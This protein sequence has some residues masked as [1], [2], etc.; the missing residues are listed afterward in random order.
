MLYEPSKKRSCENHSARYQHL[1]LSG[2][3][4]SESTV[5]FHNSLLDGRP[6]RVPGFQVSSTAV[7]EAFRLS[8]TLLAG[9]SLRYKGY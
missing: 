8:V 6:S 7:S 9:K 2:I 3:D 1:A 4:E 5:E